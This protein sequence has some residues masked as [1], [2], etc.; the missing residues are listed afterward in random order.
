MADK[1]N[2]L[3]IDDDIDAAEW[4][5]YV[6]RS[7]FPQLE[8][9]IRLTPNIA[10]PFDLYFVDNDFHGTCL[11]GELACAIRAVNPRA[12]IV[13]VSA[14]LDIGTLKRLVNVGC[15]GACDKSDPTDVSRMQSI[16][17]AYIERTDEERRQPNGQGFFGA[18]RSIRGLLKEWN[19]RLETNPN[20][21]A[22]AA[23][24]RPAMIG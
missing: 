15:D 24:S 4:L 12:L 9:T 3:I 16:V 1:L 8:V 20:G 10:G 2:A 7:R 5:S 14:R 23:Q 18:I 17:A 11:A 19:Q 21:V 6:L 22:Y 13:A